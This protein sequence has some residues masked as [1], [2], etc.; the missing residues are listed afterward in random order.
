MNLY[1]IRR[2]FLNLYQVKILKLFGVI[3]IETHGFCNR[4]CEFCYNNS[5]F[6][7]R[8]EGKMPRNLCYK[9]IDELSN[10]N[11]T[12]RIY[13]HFFNEPLLDER[14][15]EIIS[16]TRDKCPYSYIRFS[17]NGDKLTETMLKKLINRG[18]D[19]ILIT[20]CDNNVRKE[21][22]NLSLKYPEY[23]R[24]RN[25]K[26]LNFFNRFNMKFKKV[27]P[28]IDAPCYRPFIQL[29]IN[30]K[31]DAVLCC[32]DY[33]GNYTIGNIK[34]K[35]IVEIWRGKKIAKYRKILSNKEGRN[36]IEICKECSLYTYPLHKMINPILKLLS[37]FQE[38][39]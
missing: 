36:K 27:N 15:P 18:L 37:Y 21:L 2:K 24:Y 31:G 19:K 11:Y 8:E 29:I 38:K 22:L 34:E 25:W 10:L 1:N 9:V 23:V 39:R 20:N 32:N 12:G 5:E 26:D 35:S 7:D 28:N 33:Y 16:Y 30:W 6:P 17:S 13:F 4:K 3:N 14:L